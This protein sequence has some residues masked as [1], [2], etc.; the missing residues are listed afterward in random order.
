VVF[1][2]EDIGV[3][4]GSDRTYISKYAGSISL[5]ET[6]ASYQQ[7]G[8]LFNGGIEEITAVQDGA[9]TD[10]IYTYDLP[11][12]AAPSVETYTIEAGDNQ[13]EEQMLYCFVSDF[14]ISGAGGGPLNCAGTLMGR[15]VN[16]GTFTA[17]IAVPTVETILFSKGKLYLDASGGTI[18]STQ[19]SNTLLDCSISN[20]PN[21]RLRLMS[22][23]SI[24]PAR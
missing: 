23:L 16:T 19:V 3:F 11:T 9:G 17:A 2:E 8:Y 20:T 21:Q 15:Q 24:M 12:T 6:P 7:I 1:V 4:S 5:D 10:Y 14:T 18:G 13:Q 22:P